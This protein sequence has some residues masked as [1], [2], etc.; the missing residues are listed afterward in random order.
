[1]NR[2]SPSLFPRETL[3]PSAAAKV[4]LGA[5]AVP[6]LIQRLRA[7]WHAHRAADPKGPLHV[8]ARHLIA[9]TQTHLAPNDIVPQQA[10]C[11]LDAWLGRQPGASLKAD[12]VHARLKLMSDAL[13]S[14]EWEAARA[15]DATA[16]QARSDLVRAAQGGIEARELAQVLVKPDQNGRAEFLQARQAFVDMLDMKPADPAG[17]VST[18][19]SKRLAKQHTYRERCF[20]EGIG[21]RALWRAA[22]NAPE[23]LA[24]LARERHKLDAH[25]HRFNEFR[26]AGERFHLEAYEQPWKALRSLDAA[27]KDLRATAGTRDAAA[28]HEAAQRFIR[29][30]DDTVETLRQLGLQ[31]MRTHELAPGLLPVDRESLRRY[32]KSLLTDCIPHLCSPTG[33]LGA[34]YRLATLAGSDNK[35]VRQKTLKLLPEARHIQIGLKRHAGAH[36]AAPQHQPDTA[37]AEPARTVPDDDL[38]SLMKTVRLGAAELGQARLRVAVT[39]MAAPATVLPSMA[40]TRARLAEIKVDVLQQRLAELRPLASETQGKAPAKRRP[41]AN[42]RTPSPTPSRHSLEARIRDAQILQ[43]EHELRSATLTHQRL[44]HS[45]TLDDEPATVTAL[46]AEYQAAADLALQATQRTAD[47]LTALLKKS[48]GNGQDSDAERIQIE[49]ERATSMAISASQ[50]YALIQKERHA[51]ERQHTTPAPGQQ[52]PEPVRDDVIDPAARDATRPD[53]PDEASLPKA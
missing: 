24:R 30:H 28:L 52:A 38:A 9:D 1:M 18:K 48:P 27:A 3:Q 22:A 33:L 44:V 49:I 47:I 2:L 50:V 39:S 13:S 15:A 45:V 4:R 7:R 23:A 46:L 8:A 29:K 31:L 26:N 14:I 6:R 12:E 10:A 16:T 53:R 25:H 32:G 21:E 17:P 41:T 19:A 5:A 43:L 51:F 11:E 34:T 20:Y 37:P 36:Q 42:V 40:Q 35:A